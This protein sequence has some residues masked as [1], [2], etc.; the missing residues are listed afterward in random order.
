MKSET[1]SDNFIFKKLNW[2]SNKLNLEAY[3]LIMCKEIDGAGI[4]DFQ[5]LVGLADL[6]VFKNPTSMRVNSKFISD[7]TKAILYDTNVSFRLD[8]KNI[9]EISLSDNQDFR[10]EILK[11]LD[12]DY[13]HLL[14]FNN[15]RFVRDTKLQVELGCN[16]YK[17][18]IVNSFN[19]I[20]KGFFTIKYKNK[21]SGFILF[22]EESDN[23]IIELI[24]IDSKLQKNGIG[25]ILMKEFINLSLKKNINF[26]IVGTQI[27]NIPAINFYIKNGFRVTDTIDIYHWWR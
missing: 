12:F 27:S 19:L 4:N 9:E 2:E 15:S 26:I 23:I 8:L 5:Q 6:V 24:S 7:Y 16:I 10:F 1:T 18:W 21:Q 22:K 20:N 17:D 3:E 13:E 11:K 14:E 25:S